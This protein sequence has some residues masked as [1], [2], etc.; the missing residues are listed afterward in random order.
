[1]AAEIGHTDTAC[2]YACSDH[3]SWTKVGAPSAFT[4]ESTFADSNHNIHSAN[5]KID[6]SPEFSFE[7]MA[8]FSRLAISLAVELGGGESLGFE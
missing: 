5:D 1:M 7:H 3:A 6:Y 4:I 2:G 8:Q